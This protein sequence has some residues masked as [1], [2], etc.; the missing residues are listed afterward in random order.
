MNL[1][2]AL[3]A[4]SAIGWDFDG[5]LIDHPSSHLMYDFIRATP[6]KRHIIVTFRSHGTQ[7]A[8]FNV[9]DVVGGPHR[10][11]FEALHN[12]PDE[13]WEAYTYGLRG[14][15]R[16]LRWKGE[17]CS[18]L[19]LTLLVDDMTAHVVKGCRK[20]GIEHLHPDN[21]NPP[22]RPFPVTK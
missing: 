14:G 11:A 20:F 1:H 16:Y 4:H 7:N 13:L 22:R 19:G 2:P 3:T 15:G 21:L 6:H 5:T 8:V 12:V 18:Q 9:L 17:V 10:T